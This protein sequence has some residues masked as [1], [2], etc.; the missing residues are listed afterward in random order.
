MMGKILTAY[1]FLA[2]RLRE[3]STMAS[4]SAVLL[5]LGVNLDPGLVHNWLTTLGIG[6]GVFG[7]FVKEGKAETVIK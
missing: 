5:A 4:L 6:M 7:V 2:A 1:I 3:P